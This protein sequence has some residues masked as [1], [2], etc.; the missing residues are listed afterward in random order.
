MGKIIA[1]RGKKE[2][3]AVFNKYARLSGNQ[4]QSR[5]QSVADFVRY[6][7]ALPINEETKAELKAASKIPV[8]VS[9]IDD[10]SVPASMKIPINVSDEEWETAMEIFKQV[11]DLKKTQMPYFIKV[12][13]IACIKKIEEQN[14]EL[15]IVEKKVA[16]DVNEKVEIF[17]T[18]S[19][20]D[21]LVK[22]YELLN[23][24]SM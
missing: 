13:G 12:A 7:A 5:T 17:R 4:N 20:E 21:K 22:I 11:F 3:V 9:S 14:A 18:L 10:S 2:I 19:T 1:V 23:E 24:R 6:V 16:E 8:D 15:G